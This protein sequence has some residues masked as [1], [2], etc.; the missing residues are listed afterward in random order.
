MAM[1]TRPNGLAISETPGW[2][3]IPALTAVVM[4]HSGQ[5]IPVMARRGHG[6]P[7]LWATWGSAAPSASMAPPGARSGATS[8]LRVRASIL[9]GL[10]LGDRL[11]HRA[12]GTAHELLPV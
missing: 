12:D 11:H 2:P 7:G 9:L 8:T 1:T 6:N 10:V 4:P 5:G 3:F